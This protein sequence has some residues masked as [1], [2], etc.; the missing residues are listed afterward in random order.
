MLK[1]KEF[2]QFWRQLSE[3]LDE[4][5]LTAVQVE[6]EATQSVVA[7]I[8]EHMAEQQSSG[9]FRPMD[10]SDFRIPFLDLDSQIQ[11]IDFSNAE[12]PLYQ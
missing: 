6:N 9:F 3:V 7:S 2:N 10:Y 4:G 5:I 11:R 1:V 8:A 12:V